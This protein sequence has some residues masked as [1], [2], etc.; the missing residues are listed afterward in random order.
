V[1]LLAYAAF[2]YIFCRGLDGSTNNRYMTI[3][4]IR[5]VYLLPILI[6]VGISIGKTQ[7]LDEFLKDE[8]YFY[9]TTKQVNQFFRR[10]NGEEDDRGIRYAPTDRQF[11]HPDIRR[12]YINMLFDNE[13]AGYSNDLK[14]SFIKDVNSSRPEFLDF[15]GQNWFAEV[16]ASFIFNGREHNAV[17]FLNLEKAGLGSKWV[18]DQVYFE[19]FA[20]M[21]DV[22]T[23]R[24]HLFLHPMS[25]EI[26][27]MTLNKAFNNKDKV[28]NYASREYRPDYLSIFLYEIKKGNI[29]FKSVRNVK[30]HFFQINNWY[31]EISEFNRRGHNKGWLISNLVKVPEDQKILLKEYIYFKN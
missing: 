24:N 7:V 21:F 26:D 17:L 28:E 31:F 14:R 16:H 22:D 23:S 8:V 30:F 20:K 4:L 2:V 3:T 12:G 10:F 19:P 1:G 29:Q 15:H 5:T 18:F 11:R 6:L 25:H 27:F 13:T 9:S